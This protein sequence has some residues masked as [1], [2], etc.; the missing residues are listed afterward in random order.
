MKKILVEIEKDYISFSLSFDNSLDDYNKTNIFNGRKI[1]FSDTFILDNLKVVGILINKLVKNLN[2]NKVVINNNEVAEVI[3]M[4]LKYTPNIN[5]IYFREDKSLTYTECSLISENKYLDFINC[6]SMP[7]Y[8]FDR[9]NMLKRIR[10]KI[11]SEI[12]TLSNFMD[13]NKMQ[14]YSDIYYKKK[15]VI[16]NELEKEDIEDIIAF[17]KINKYLKVIELKSYDYNNMLI[18]LNTMKKYRVERIVVI[19]NQLNN[20]L[21]EG[22]EEFDKI[23]AQYK[24]NIKVKYNE[25]YKRRNYIK[26]I[27]I[28]IIKTILIILIML[29][30]SIIG[31][32]FYLSHRDNKKIENI[33]QSINDI[34]E[35]NTKVEEEVIEEEKEESE[36]VDEPT[37]NKRG[38]AYYTNYKQVFSELLKINSDTVGWIKVNNT[39]V[40]YPVVQTKDNDYYLKHAFDKE[41]NLAGWVF[42]DYRNNIDTLN[43]NTIIYGHNITK[44]RLMFGSL[45]NTLNESWYKNSENH[46]ITFNTL[47]EN[48][49]WQIF[50]L[51]TIEETSDYLI[52]SFSSLNSF[53]NYI[54][55]ETNRS[56]YNFNVDVS[57]EDKILTL[58]TCYQDDKHRLVIH[59]KKVG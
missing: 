24:I 11:R 42:M 45:R 58:S 32:Y 33:N 34:I 49:K 39:K 6:Y 56:I 22:I 53:K 28:N 16:S 2:T 44:D 5:K 25:E 50:S 9:L 15:I 57:E 4:L 43:Q 10:V 40:N 8:L 17:F 31:L 13:E 3:L 29:S 36:E 51:Y 55:R 20:E 23:E 12:F 52:T 14:T 21:I 7:E 30:I 46:I 19:I 1:K 41:Y 37:E 26:Q 38:Q 27:N 59:A 35:E 18:L 54:E 48:S 47:N